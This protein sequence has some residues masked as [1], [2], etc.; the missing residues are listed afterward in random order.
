MREDTNDFI[1]EDEVITK[2][3]AKKERKERKRFEDMSYE[4]KIAAHRRMVAVRVLY[5]V[6]AVLILVCVFVAVRHFITYSAY[7]VVEKETRG[8]GTSVQYAEYYGKLLRYS[9]DGAMF[10]EDQD[11][12]IW[13]EAYEMHNPIVD[14]CGRY[15][16]IADLYGTNVCIFNLEGKKASLEVPK[17]IQ[18]VQISEKGSMALLLQDGEEHILQY[19]DSEGTL[20]AEGKLS[21]IKSG[22]PLDMS[23]SDDGLKLAVSYLIVENGVAKSNLAFYSF[24]SVGAA[25]IDNVVSSQ[26]YENV[27]IPSVYYADDSTA[28]AFGDD[29]LLFFKGSQRPEAAGEVIVSEEIQSVFYNEKYA[30]MV[31]EDGDGYRMDVYNLNGVRILS[32]R[33]DFAYT[34]I[35]ISG[36]YIIMYNSKEW[37]IYTI[38]GRVRLAPCELGGAVTD[39]IALSSNKFLLVKANKTQTVKLRL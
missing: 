27:L 30:G 32:Q 34:N 24:S 18:M 3:K 6:A 26:S 14:I 5:A 13:N 20:I 9:K 35:K 33:F 2:R 1:G 21:F 15:V 29:R 22:Y 8:A 4:E 37:C 23:L 7:D 19:Y 11:K 16:A 12:A 17:P 38:N 36:G 25:N 10:Y 31:L 28:F 39:I